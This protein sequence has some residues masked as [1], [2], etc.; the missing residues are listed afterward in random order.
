[1]AIGFPEFPGLVNFAALHD[2]P[3]FSQYIGQ[4]CGFQ[5]KEDKRLWGDYVI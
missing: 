3:L 1:M 5:K 4:L 2:S